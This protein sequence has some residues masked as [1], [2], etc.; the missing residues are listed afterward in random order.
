[1]V[2]MG[3][4][5]GIAQPLYTLIVQNAFPPQ[6]LGVVTCGHHLLP[7]HR[8]HGG[9][10]D[11]RH[12]R[13]QPLHQRVPGAPAQP[14]LK[15]NPQFGAFLSNLSPQALISPDT[16]TATP[17]A[18]AGPRTC[19]RRRSSR[20]SRPSR[21]RS[22]PA[23]GAAT[24]G[25]FLIGAII[26]AISTVVV[27]FIPEIAL[28]RGASR[29]AANVEKMAEEGAAGGAQPGSGGERTGRLNGRGSQVTGQGCLFGPTRR[30]LL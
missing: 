11:L 27:V 14:Q 17:A 7:L 4:G 29:Q 9:R 26:L 23:L 5:L 28:R 16:I 15:D 3:V 1:M 24:T 20:C 8:R 22:S 19:R 12:R 21:R 10:G 18:V 13:Q 2:V 6:R 30:V 25:A